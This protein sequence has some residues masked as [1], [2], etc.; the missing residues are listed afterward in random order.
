MT[1]F[2]LRRAEEV[3]TGNEP[4]NE[5]WGLCLVLEKVE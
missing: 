1:G 5:T 2:K 4:S 3:L